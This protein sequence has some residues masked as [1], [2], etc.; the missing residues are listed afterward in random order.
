MYTC[1]HAHIPQQAYSV[2]AYLMAAGVLSI[3]KRLCLMDL[4]IYL[5]VVYSACGSYLP[6]VRD[7][8]SDGELQF[9]S[10]VLQ[11]NLR[12]RTDTGLKIE[13]ESM[14]VGG[15]L[16][17]RTRHPDFEGLV[18]N[19]ASKFDGR[20]CHLAFSLQVREV[21]NARLP[22]VWKPGTLPSKDTSTVAHS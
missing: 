3:L 20:R 15:L 11:V 10:F 4:L 14:S 16:T 21:G 2:L 9:A 7:S 17:T 18:S 13:R 1:A 22:M 12:D 19:V 6:L 8:M 5:F